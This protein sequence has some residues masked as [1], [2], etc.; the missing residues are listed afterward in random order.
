MFLRK[1][2]AFFDSIISW[3]M[4]VEEWKILLHMF[5]S[6]LLSLLHLKVQDTPHALSSHSLFAWGHMYTNAYLQSKIN[7]SANT[8]FSMNVYKNQKFPF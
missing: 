2:T 8:G 6:V 3:S 4:F 1:K 7:V 5:F